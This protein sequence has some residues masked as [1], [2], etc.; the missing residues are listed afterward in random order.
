MK[1]NKQSGAYLG[2]FAMRYD[3]A[4]AASKLCGQQINDTQRTWLQRVRQAKM[5]QVEVQNNPEVEVR[6]ASL[7]WLT[8]DLFGWASSLEISYVA[9][10]RLDL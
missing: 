2:C 8:L 4:K 3:W 5:C 1:Q 7:D 9:L 6:R 10:A